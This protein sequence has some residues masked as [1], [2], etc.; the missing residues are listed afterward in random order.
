MT[1]RLCKPMIFVRQVSVEEIEY[2]LVNVNGWDKSRIEG[3]FL[4]S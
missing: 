2:E 3:D 1:R 4:L